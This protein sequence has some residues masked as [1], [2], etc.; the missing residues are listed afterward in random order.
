MK[1]QIKGLSPWAFAAALL[2]T[3]FIPL[4]D[5][6]ERRAKAGAPNNAVQVRMRNIVYHFADDI[7]VHIRSLHGEIVPTGNNPFPIF[8]D[9]NSFILKIAG[10]VI[11]ITP[12]S[13]A[14]VI[15]AHIGKSAESPI[16]DISIRIENS[17]LKVRGKLRST[18]V[19]FELDGTVS[20]TAAGKIRLHANNIRAF[21]LPVRRLMD[22]FGVEVASLMKRGKLP[23][24]QA[25]GDD[26]IL[27]PEQLLPPPRMQSKVS[28]VH[29]EANNIVQTF[30]TLDKQDKDRDNENYMHYEGNRLKFGKLTMND[31]DLTLLD[32]D[33]SDP[34]DFY[35]A[36]YKEQLVAG[37]TKT[38]PSFGL[39]V[40]M[41]DFNKLG[42]S[43]SPRTAAKPG[44]STTV[45]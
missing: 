36:H 9:K 4:A 24:I 42:Q 39:R 20:A 12:A 6:E 44:T 31:T 14:N 21:K 32:L 26:L 41:V 43:K 7:T 11:A 45:R 28:E 38:T 2:L 13:M 30:G 25:E 8:D 5:S 3:L 29:L 18:G 15:N 37:Y 1:S 27:S 33:A 10:G 17:Q 16:K 34:F 19:P 35:L 40:Y 23:G 22:L